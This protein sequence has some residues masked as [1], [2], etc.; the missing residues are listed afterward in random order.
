M[1]SGF[2]MILLLLGLCIVSVDRTFSQ[3]QIVQT[4]VFSK[5]EQGYHTFRI[6]AI[7]KTSGGVLL[8]FAEGRKSARADY[9]DIDLVLKRS[10]DMGMSW[11][12]LQLIWN[13]NQNTCGNPAPIL[14]EKTGKITL[15]TTWNLGTDKEHLIIEGTSQDTRRVFVLESKDEGT[16]WSAP[17]E[18]TEQVK[19]DDWTWYATGPGSGLQ[20]GRGPHAGRLILGCDHIEAESKKY[21]SHVIYS[22]DG[23]KKWT[24]GGS[25]PQDQVNECEVA[26]LPQGLLMLNMRNYNRSKKYRQTAISRDG[27]LQWSDQKHD[28]QLVEPRCQASLQTHRDLKLL[29]FSNPADKNERIKMTLQFS[30]DWGYSWP[31]SVVLHE[32]PA[33]YSD[34]VILDEA[35]VG[36]LYEKGEQN[37]Y[38]EIVFAKVPLNRN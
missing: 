10:N 12:P 16:S 26:E 9:G 22:D 19:K 8:A 27:G 31:T 1:R 20:I 29:L 36:C 14:D 28:G 23:G 2:S 30:S 25:T 4:T 6:P 38:E 17:L 13:D 21:Y 24:L 37:P 7:I 32:G 18:I 3:A 35:N 33:A 15:L 5:G 11:G 34:I